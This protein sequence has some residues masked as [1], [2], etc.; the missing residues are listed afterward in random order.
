MVKKAVG[1]MRMTIRVEPKVL[2]LVAY[3]ALRANSETRQ[4]WEISH[5]ALGFSTPKKTKRKMKMKMKMKKVM[6]MIQTPKVPLHG[7][8]SLRANTCLRIM[9]TMDQMMSPNIPSILMTT[10]LMS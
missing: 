2:L 10:R 5:S 3:R 7:Q 1:T 6:P 9:K 8:T 4:Q